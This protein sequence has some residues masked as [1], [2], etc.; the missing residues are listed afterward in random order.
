MS[1]IAL[2][3]G[4]TG[5]DGS[6]LAELLLQKQYEVHGIVRRSSSFNT[7]R[8]DHIFNRLHLH[9]GDITDPV[10]IADIVNKVK[11]DEVY[12]L[13]AQSVHGRSIITVLQP[14]KQSNIHHIRIEDLFTNLQNGGYKVEIENNAEIINLNNKSQI[15]IMS[16]WNGMGTFLKLKQISRHKY[17]GKM[18]HMYQRMG[19]VVVTPNH[20]IYDSNFKLTTPNDNPSLFAIRQLNYENYRKLNSIELSPNLNGINYG[21]DANYI[22][23]KS[24]P[25]KKIKRFI[26]GRDI[27]LWM[28]FSGAFISEGH[29]TY[30][31]AN[32][33]HLIGISNKNHQWLLKLKQTLSTIFKLPMCIITHK[34]EKYEP[35]YELQ[36]NS[37]LLYFICRSLFGVDCY[38]KKI[39]SFFF[40]LAKEKLQI[41]LDYLVKGDG[42]IRKHDNYNNIEYKTTSDILCCQLSFLF[43][44][45]NKN[46]SM[47]Y[48]HIKHDQYHMAYNINEVKS[49]NPNCNIIKKLYWEDYDGYVYDVSVDETQNFVIGPG[50]IVVHNSHVMVSFE[51]PFYTA[52]VD[53]VGTLNILEAVRQSQD[54]I[55]KQIRVYQASTSELFG[56][57]PPPHNEKTPFHPR[58]PYACAKLYAYHQAVNYREAYGLFASNG[59][60][61]NHESVRR[62]ETFISRKVTRAAARIALGLQKDLTVGNLNAY[63]DWGH[64]PEFVEAMWMILQHVKPDDFVVATG[65]THTVAE[66]CEIA[67]SELHL[68]W[69]QYVKTDPKYL[70]P[71]EVD[72]LCGDATKI[73]KELG[74]EPQIKFK[75]LIILMV[76]HDLELAKK[77][78]A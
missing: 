3:T 77:E 66:L 24:S 65:E 52:Q 53:A 69:H 17:N 70:R 75:D 78:M 22:W 32:H 64:A 34:K 48:Q 67:F 14:Y 40:N 33:A 61:F 55:G 49:Y 25:H 29:T 62:G 11:P 26:T 42:T 21:K 76:K 9:Y 23:L 31:R 72:I 38:N 5:Q 15:K 51:V 7:G 58:S 4:I 19:A 16:C 35:V 13:G 2:I 36:I 43:S 71:S 46:Y 8:I 63:R 27:D 47:D 57:T 73:K 20:S 60:L 1:K 59:I 56:S 37:E 45:L 6:F 44:L 28:E 74:W 10:S 50:N 30:N 18:A 54:K 39:P 12:H 68:D 41:L